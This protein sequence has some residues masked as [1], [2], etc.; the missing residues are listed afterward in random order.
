MLQKIG[1][2]LRN[3]LTDELHLRFRPDWWS[4][5][6]DDGWSE[7]GRDLAQ[8]A[9]EIGS[10]QYFDYL[11]SASHVLRPDARQ[12]V[13][14]RD[15]DST[16]AKLFTRHVGKNLEPNQFLPRLKNGC[17]S[18]FPWRWVFVGVAVTIFLG[19]FIS[20]SID[21]NSPH[22]GGSSQQRVRNDRDSIAP[23]LPAFATTA[24]PAYSV[25]ST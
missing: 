13:R 23:D 7:F 5:L 21:F 17:V 9:K 14:I 1:I 10:A 25:G 3:K 4:S 24:P 11:E 16:L 8:Q 2:L 22:S 19:A 18:P 12:A 6:E 15:V 20:A